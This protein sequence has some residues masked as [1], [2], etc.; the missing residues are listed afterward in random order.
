MKKLMI[1]GAGLYQVPLIETAKKMGLETVVVSI[2][3]PYKGFE[4][5]DHVLELDTRDQNAIRHAAVSEQISG[6]C[7]TGTDVA[8][9][10]IGYVCDRLNLPGIGYE[11]ARTLCDKA[12]MKE[13]FL[14]GK[15]ACA[16]GC[17]VTSLREA[18]EAAD[19]LGYPVV[20][21]RV[22][23]SGSRGI[24]VVREPFALRAAFLRAK[25]K[26]L[27]E[28]VLVEQFLQGTEIG[29]DGF[30]RDGKVIFLAPHTKFVFKGGSITVPSGHAY[31]FPGTPAL[32]RE[33]ARQMQLAASAA[34]ADNCCF[35]ADVFVEGDRAWV[36][37]MGGRCGATCIP[38][39]TSIYYGFDYYEAMILEAIGE[40]AHF[41]D[42]GCMESGEASGGADT[43][44][45]A[46]GR[47]A[48]K[49]LRTPCMAK[50]L[51]SPSEGVITAI[52]EGQ[53]EKIRQGG[54]DVKL[55][56]HVGG[57]VFA[58]SDGTDRIGSVLLRTGE[59]SVLDETCRAVR[60]CIW[61]NE[62]NLEELWND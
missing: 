52:D 16:A 12:L 33:I 7:T 59:E 18:Q 27:H 38:E 25:E 54:A 10:S 31:P 36:I 42:T 50:L 60:R 41:P 11:A 5:A 15:V 43:F 49:P 26:T 39:L 19:R 9:K 24:T 17:R 56:F 21:K 55:D 14:R 48:D 22:D 58:M 44:A 30:I 3:G 51:M 46:S 47:G 4:I 37:E 32:R 2:P 35:N 53:L 61:V 45:C 13:A 1:L 20:V 28:Y 57:H 40:R 6:I 8:V 34:G 62:R 29:V 23:S